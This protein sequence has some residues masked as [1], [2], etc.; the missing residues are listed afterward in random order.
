[1]ALPY[2]RLFI[3]LIQLQELIRMTDRE[4]I[5]R[6]GSWSVTKLGLWN[7][8]KNYEISNSDLYSL[9]LIDYI[10]TV[11]W[12]D[13]ENFNIA[14]SIAKVYYQRRLNPYTPPKSAST[15]RD[16]FYK[17]KG[18]ATGFYAVIVVKP[19]ITPERCYIGVVQATD[20]KGLRLTLI[21][22]D[23][24]AF[25]SWD[26]YVSWENI[27]SAMVATPQ[28]SAQKFLEDAMKWVRAFNP[29]PFE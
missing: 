1:M 29:L 12:G 28:H 27:D 8:A 19:G 22:W 23:V 2:G 18:I 16:E 24:K 3:Q 6:Y 14:L 4:V 20:D 10:K 15:S 7:E 11:E 5:R 21:D 9:E 26:L 25:E 13:Y 17:N